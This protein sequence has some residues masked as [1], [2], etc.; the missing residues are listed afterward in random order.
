MKIGFS[1]YHP[2][3]ICV[4]KVIR[5]KRHLDS[6]IIGY[7]VELTEIEEQ[8]KKVIIKALEIVEFKKL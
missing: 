1:R 4:G 7:A 6:C 3:V 2:T 5:V 8:K